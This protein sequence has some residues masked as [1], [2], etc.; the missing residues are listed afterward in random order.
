VNDAEWMLLSAVYHRVLAQSLSPEAAKIAISTAR[1]NGQLRMRATVHEHKAQPDLR[2]A[3]GEQPPQIPPVITP[4]HPIC[5]TDTFDR[6]DWERNDASRR[7]S[8]T[9]SLFW[10]RQIEINQEDALALCPEKA[11]A[12]STAAAIELAWPGLKAKKPNDIEPKVWSAMKALAAVETEGTN[13][14]SIPKPELL[15]L[16]TSR[17][18]EGAECSISTLFKARKARDEYKTRKARRR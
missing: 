2:L 4:D 6:W 1:K 16:V 7:D 15:K 12:E 10:Y 17:M 18:W 3:P 11:P 13:L 14:E 8:E 9:Q 5:P